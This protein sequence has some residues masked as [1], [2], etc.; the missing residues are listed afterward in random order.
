MTDGRQDGLR[1]WLSQVSSIGELARMVG[2]A[3]ASATAQTTSAGLGMENI[4]RCVASTFV[5]PA[6]DVTVTQGVGFAALSTPV[7][8]DVVLS[9]RPIRIYVAAS[10]VTA[11]SAIGGVHL[12]A[13]LRGTEVTGRVN[14]IPGCSW[15]STGS[16]TGL[17]GEHIVTAP[18]P[19]QA[20]IK[21]AAMAVTTDATIWGGTA[22]EYGVYLSI[23]EL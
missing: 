19:G 7:Q 18:A 17:S 6:A 13:L 14:G 22:N 11:G 23:T 2:R 16:R 3:N 4:R 1:D 21:V 15:Y 9:G 8:L 5:V 20:T 12:S 10:A